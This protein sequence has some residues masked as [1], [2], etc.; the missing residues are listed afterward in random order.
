MLRTPLIAI[1]ATTA[2]L[3]SMANATETNILTCTVGSKQLSLSKQDDNIIYKFGPAGKPELVLREPVA[4]VDF[5]PWNG[6][7]ST[8]ADAVTF[9]NQN[10]SYT[11]ITTSPYE[12]FR[13]GIH[14]HDITIW[15][16]RD[17]KEV[18]IL[19]CNEQTAGDALDHL[20]EAKAAIGQCWDRELKQWSEDCSD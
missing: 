3:P 1:L 16:K 2:L 10:Y 20:R 9:Y 18:A 11:V 13:N 8:D 6:L 15:V 17:G 14:Y 5:Q 4:T 12:N 19:R 7:G